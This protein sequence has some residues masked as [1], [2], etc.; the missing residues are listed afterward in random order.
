M[1]NVVGHIMFSTT[2]DKVYAQ[3]DGLLRPLVAMMA[4][5]ADTTV[6]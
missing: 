2:Y 6:L 3:L 1:A 4:V 5:I